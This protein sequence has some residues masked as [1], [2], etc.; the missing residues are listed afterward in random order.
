MTPIVRRSTTKSIGIDR[1]HTDPEA[2]R[3]V[4][5]D[6]RAIRQRPAHGA[7]GEE[8]GHPVSAEEIQERADQFRRVRGLHRATD[9]NQYLD[10][11]RGQPGRVRGLRHRQP[12][13]G[14]DDGSRSAAT[15]AVRGVLQAELAEVR[16]HR[17]EPHRAR[18]RRQGQGDD[19]VLQRR[20]RQLRR[21]GA[22]AFDRRHARA[23]RPD[24]Q[25]AARLAE[26]RRRGQGVQ[27]RGRR[28]ARAVSVV[29][30]VASTRSSG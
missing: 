14:E 29:R 24:R 2:H 10:A 13:P 7:G 28:P 19:L 5:G 26:H 9:T 17:G 16:Q 3:A 15:K 1:I 11:P 30:P 25:G 22:R 20:S 6:H 23:G 8:A 18:H 4:G 12:V 27:R 21:D